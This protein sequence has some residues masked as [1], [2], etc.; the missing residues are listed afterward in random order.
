MVGNKV[1]LVEWQKDF[2][3]VAGKEECVILSA[4]TGSGKTRCYEEWAFSKAERPIFITAPI[5][6]LS[7]Q[8]FGALK[9][10]GYKVA[11]ETGDISY[12]P[13]DEC[14]IVCCTQEIYNI[15]YRD[16]PNHTLVIDEFAY[17][18]NDFSR[19]RAY[20]DSIMYSNASNIFICSATMGKSNEV[21][22]YINKISKRNF[23]FYETNERLTELEYIGEIPVWKIRNSLVVAYSK[24]ECFRLAKLL[25]DRRIENIRKIKTLS[26]PSNRYKG[27]I[28]EL[29][30]KY[31]VTNNKLIDFAL[32]GV[33][34]YCGRLLPKEKLFVEALLENGY[35]DTVVGTDALALGV[36]FPIE[37]VV[38]SKLSSGFSPRNSLKGN[39]GKLI[40]K[41]MFE[42]LSGRAGRKSFYDKG[43]VYCCSDFYGYKLEDDFWK[44]VNA[45]A[46]PF[47]IIVGSDIISILKGDLTVED[48]VNLR[49]FLSTEELDYDK[50]L[51]ETQE[52]VDF[53]R[54]LDVCKYYF[55]HKY[56][57]DI[58]L[59]FEDAIKDRR[60][61]EQNKFRKEY[62]YLQ[63]IQYLFEKYISNTYM[64]EYSPSRNCSLLIDILL[65]V[66]IEKMLR[67]YCYSKSS[68]DYEL[69]SLL[70]FRKYMKRIPDEYSELYN[71]EAVD[72][73]INAIDPMVLNPH[74]SG[75]AKRTSVKAVN[76]VEST[77]KF[78][79]KGSNKDVLCPN[80][81]DMIEYKGKKY[82]KILQENDRIL[83]CDY[84]KDVEDDI[85]LSYIPLK[86]IY[87]ICGYI[88][89]KKMKEL[90]FRMNFD[91]IGEYIDDV[92]LIDAFSFGSFYKHVLEKSK[93][94]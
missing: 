40:S 23:A 19:A 5:K 77:S 94:R 7:N 20:V 78:S 8:K 51:K 64:C 67:I 65:G 53:I 76:K 93:N 46:E 73:I 45:D 63:S 90:F 34:Y 24:D 41:N 11:L 4:P 9:A 36:N 17:I 60:I 1:E 31:K 74:K 18:Y 3:K 58:S 33:V 55:S 13:D 85:N 37:N 50:I 6:A 16:Y 82:I 71:V 2:L 30:N 12:F 49:M 91:S 66:P 15:K 42:Q 75:L 79:Y 80:R 69:M 27:A 22:N 26:D 14:D 35:V 87:S 59:G 29:A 28:K 70:D 38:F 57:I 88:N 44:L 43:C 83:V 61:N 68:D 10:R 86:S 56:K 48:D 21:V 39:T 84:S 81:F 92:Q 25:Y 89:Y 72:A 54:N 47:R 32:M 62:Q 52:T